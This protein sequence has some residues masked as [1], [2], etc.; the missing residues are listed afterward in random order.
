MTIVRALVS[1]VTTRRPKRGP[2]SATLANS[3]VAPRA[4]TPERPARAA[5]APISSDQAP[6]RRIRACRAQYASTMI[7][8]ATTGAA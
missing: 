5:M 8:S 7:N 4:N 1:V 3:A 6:A 2:A